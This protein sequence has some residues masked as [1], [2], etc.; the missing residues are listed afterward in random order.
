MGLAV[1]DA[2]GAPYEGLT[3][4]DIFFQFG[5]PDGLVKNQAIHGGLLLFT[6]LNFCPAALPFVFE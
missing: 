5:S 4:A 6:C 2:V 1:A 3:N